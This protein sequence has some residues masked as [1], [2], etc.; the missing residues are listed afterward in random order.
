MAPLVFVACSDDSGLAA[1]STDSVSPT[2]ADPASAAEA[3]T[4]TRDVAMPGDAQ[5][6]AEI[7]EEKRLLAG[8]RLFD[9]WY[10]EP[11]HKGSFV[12]G[13]N[14]A[15]PKV[16]GVGGPNGDGTL[17]AADGT[18][19]ANNGH[20][21]RLRSFF[22]YDLRGDKGYYGPTYASKPYVL[23]VDLLDDAR[24]AEELVDWF[25]AGGDGL[26]AFGTVLSR[27]ELEAIADFVVGTRGGD[28][29][30]ADEIYALASDAPNFYTLLAGADVEAGKAAY[31]QTCAKCHGEDGTMV[32]IDAGEHTLGTFARQNAWEAWYT[33]LAGRPG[34]TMGPQVPA[35]LTGPEQSKWILNV[36]AALCDRA[37]YP[38][39]K[40]T[41]E[42]LEAGDPRC[43]SYLK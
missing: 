12:A 38:I 16:V 23:S 8:A 26:P 10:A 11:E 40:A 22:G 34:S 30:R 20:N 9:R 21:Y 18:P 33:T 17:N 6:E 25:D 42:D 29:A 1:P 41:T 2:I 28:V 19:A 4:S 27:A 35:G 14:P 13:G 5:P 24:S 36:L 3:D 15:T 32:P 39:G 43:G 37:A 7:A 31:A